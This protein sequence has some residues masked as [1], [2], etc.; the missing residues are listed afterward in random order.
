MLNSQ[1]E[2]ARVKY[3]TDLKSGPALHWCLQLKIG[4]RRSSGSQ[5][6]T[7]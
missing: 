4:F 6:V 1:A 5:E 2:K 3:I 7:C